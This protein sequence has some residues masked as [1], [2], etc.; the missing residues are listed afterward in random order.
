MQRRDSSGNSFPWAV[1]ISSGVPHNVATRWPSTQVK[2][3]FSVE[4]GDCDGFV[5]T[6]PGCSTSVARRA[7]H[8]SVRSSS[9][10]GS[11]VTFMPGHSS[12]DGGA[13]TSALTSR[14]TVT[15]LALTLMLCS[16]GHMTVVLPDFQHPLPG[17]W[18]KLA[19]ASRPRRVAS[20]SP[21]A[22]RFRPKDTVPRL[23]L[24]EIS[25][26]AIAI[27]FR[28][29]A[30]STE[31]RPMKTVPCFGSAIAVTSARRRISIA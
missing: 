6:S 5:S 22:S 17:S 28:L 24:F 23:E 12:A 1:P 26:S 15:S 4:R 30:A 3:P 13:S 18:M 7:P 2:R 9:P 19:L 20:T 31:P 25:R 21:A 8:N 14:D 10:R 29:S 27:G 16:F 11:S